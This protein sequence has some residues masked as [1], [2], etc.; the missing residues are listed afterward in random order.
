MTDIAEKVYDLDLAGLSGMPLSVAR[1]EL[2]SWVAKLPKHSTVR[3]PNNYIRFMQTYKALL[4]EL[5]SLT[6]DDEIRLRA[7]E[8]TF[9]R[10]NL[11]APEMITGKPSGFYLQSGQN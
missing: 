11:I 1:E 4:P 9:E 3:V 6:N 5:L 2:H 8:W 7:D 10:C